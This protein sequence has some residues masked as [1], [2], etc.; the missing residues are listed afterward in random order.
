MRTRNVITKRV[1]TRYFLNG[2]GY[3]SEAAALIAVGK[4]VVRLLRWRAARQTDLDSKLDRDE[5]KKLERVWMRERYP[6]VCKS[7]CGGGLY[8][9]GC[10]TARMRDYKRLGRLFLDGKIEYDGTPIEV[11][12]LPMRCA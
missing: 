6:C 2:R 9:Y 3:N 8:G 4:N 10:L 1:V 11:K 7:P 5:F 12:A